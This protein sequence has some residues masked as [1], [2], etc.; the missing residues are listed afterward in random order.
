MPGRWKG[1]RKYWEYIMDMTQAQERSRT[2]LALSMTMGPT[3]L[4]DAEYRMIV[5]GTPYA[6]WPDELKTK[7]GR[8]GLIVKA[9]D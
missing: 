8:L 9:E 3:E 2:M 1:D 7:T 5:L 4:T 6:E